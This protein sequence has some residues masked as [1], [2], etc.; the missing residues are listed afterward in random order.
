MGD[1][2]DIGDLMRYNGAIRGDIGRY[3]GIY[4]I[5]VEIGGDIWI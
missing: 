4:V 1:K 5:S 2:W 3:H